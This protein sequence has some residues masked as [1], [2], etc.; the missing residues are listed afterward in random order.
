MKA[1]IIG[2]SGGLGQALSARFADIGYSVTGLSRRTGNFDIRDEAS[3]Q[4]NIAAV[5]GDFDRVIIATGVLNGA[6]QGPEKALSA[7]TLEAL[8]DQFTVNAFGPALILKHLIPLVPRD[9]AIKI[10]VLSAR[11]GSIGDNA[12]GGWYSYRAAK[13][14]LNQLVHTAAIEWARRNPLSVLALLHPGTVQ[15]GFSAAYHG[16]HPTITADKSAAML[17]ETLE[18]LKP[19]NTGSFYDYRGA[20]VV[21]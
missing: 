6:G 18:S 16:S 3:I 7:L 13:T 9:R 4:K 8:A 2:Q 11:V 14:A 10:G 1:L 20:P 5:G 15:T 17:I 19:Q 21:W 12:L